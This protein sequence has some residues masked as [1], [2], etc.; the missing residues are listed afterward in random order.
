L[1]VQ[2]DSKTDLVTIL[3]NLLELYPPPLLPHPFDLLQDIPS[4]PSTLRHIY[5]FL[6]SDLPR[7]LRLI[8]RTC[9]IPDPTHKGRDLLKLPPGFIHQKYGSEFWHRRSLED[10]KE[11]LL[12]FILELM[13]VHDQALLKNGQLVSTNLLQH[14]RWQIVVHALDSALEYLK[15]TKTVIA[16]SVS[17]RNGI[18]AFVVHAIGTLASRLCKIAHREDCF[19]VQMTIE[20]GLEKALQRSVERI[21]TASRVSAS[22]DEAFVDDFMGH[23]IRPVLGPLKLFPPLAK[24]LFD[25]IKGVFNLSKDEPLSGVTQSPGERP[26]VA[27]MKHEFIVIATQF[28]LA[29]QHRRRSVFDIPKD[30]V[31]HP[32]CG[33]RETDNDAALQLL[34][35]L[36]PP[37]GNPTFYADYALLRALTRSQLEV[38]WTHFT[39]PEYICSQ[40]L[41]ESG[42]KNLNAYVTLVKELPNSPRDRLHVVRSILDHPKMDETVTAVFYSLLDISD[43]PSR[44]LLEKNT[45]QRLFTQRYPA[46]RDLM[47]ATWPQESPKEWIKT[48]AFLIPRIK[49]E[50]LPDAQKIPDILHQNGVGDFLHLMDRATEDEARQTAELYLTW[51]KQNNEAV[52]RVRF[53]PFLSVELLV[54]I[55]CYR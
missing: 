27:H 32:Y 51:E 49:N 42:K 7:T 2:K 10:Q 6:K 22:S 35:R 54:D 45:Y 8:R 4:I 18:V 1:Y 16:M 20:H 52:S 46:Y 9:H 15:S 33:I 40:L 29:L 36:E 19:E 41:D 43:E 21:L 25:S 5:S 34:L 38:L 39:E 3:F 48:L 53:S 47:T 50:I 44:E 55:W 14:A 11:Y 31:V 24:V 12:P 17:E 23:F 13:E 26:P 28:V 37:R 30:G